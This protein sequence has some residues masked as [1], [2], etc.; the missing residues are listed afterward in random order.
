[1]PRLSSTAS[2]HVFCMYPY[3]KRPSKTG[4]PITPE[5]LP[6]SNPPHPSSPV[7]ALSRSSCR[8]L[9]SGK[10]TLRR[11]HN[12]NR[13]FWGDLFRDKSALFFEALKLRVAHSR[14]ALI[15]AR[16]DVIGIH[17]TPSAHSEGYPHLLIDDMTKILSVQRL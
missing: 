4:D 15:V 5:Y 9:S 14:D 3:S 11:K 6:R 10:I 2:F 1:M 16:V 12:N 13:P 8:R 17:S 7:A